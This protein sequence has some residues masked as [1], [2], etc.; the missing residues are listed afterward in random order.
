MISPLF[1]ISKSNMHA[2]YVIYAAGSLF[3]SKTPTQKVKKK[4]TQSTEFA[5]I[6]LVELST[7]DI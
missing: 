1:Q 3:N 6:G 2:L 5:N 7:I 4:R